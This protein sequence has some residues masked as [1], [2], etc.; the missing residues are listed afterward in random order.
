M[1]RAKMVGA[2]LAAMAFIVAPATIRCS[3]VEG[4]P[5]AGPFA[6]VRS[7][8]EQ[9]IAEG[10]VPSLC[11]SVTHR[12]ETIWEEAFGWADKESG[13]RA[14]LRTP[15]LLASVTKPITATAVMVVVERGQMD[16]DRPIREYLGE[17]SLSPLG[18]SVDSVTVRHM[19]NHTSGLPLYY[20]YFYADDPREPT[21]FSEV[22]GRYGVFVEPPGRTYRYA[23][24]GYDV[25][26]H[27]VATSSGEEYGEFVRREIFVPLGMTDAFVASGTEAPQAVAARYGSDGSLLQAGGLDT[28][29]GVPVYASVRDLARFGRFHLKGH[30]E[31]QSAILSHGSLDDMH[32][33]KDPEVVYDTDSYGLGW[34]FREGDFGYRTFWHEGGMSGTSI[35]LKLV[36]D[37]DI[38][39]AL[40]MNVFDQPTSNAVTN[41]ILNVLLPQYAE[42]RTRREAPTSNKFVSYQPSEEFTGVWRG[43]IRT[44]EGDVPVYMV[45]EEDADIHVLTRPFFNNS[46]VL[47]GQQLWDAVL[48]NTGMLGDRIY[49]WTTIAIPTEDASYYPYVVI[50]DVTREENVISGAVTAVTAADRMYYALSSYIRLEKD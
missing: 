10:S 34:F 32:W 9:K 40:T 46:V 35:M 8:I 43:A 30:L 36:P 44:H 1:A 48:N 38:C 22:V 7:L 16:L 15:Y 6:E 50:V 37:E 29:G 45:F 42:N 12:G 21:V 41:A 24:L 23:N 33:G 14:T 4:D 26:C 27:A 19:L 3:A 47:Q 2:A 20:N 25:L 11:A 39:I 17:V 5:A 18:E 28:A 31:G 13:T 49:G